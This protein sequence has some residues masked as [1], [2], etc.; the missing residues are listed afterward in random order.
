MITSFSHA[1]T[2]RFGSGSTILRARGN[3]PLSIEQLQTVAPSVFAAEAHASRSSRYTYIPTVD[4][5]RGLMAEGF[6]PY[7]VR[8]GGS[9]DEA[10]RGFTKH[11]L[12]LRHASQGAALVGGDSVR[13]LILL[14]AHDGT[15]SYQLMSGLFRM[16]CTNGL[17]TCEGGEML[18]IAHKGDIISNVIEG[19][20]QILADSAVIG[21]RVEALQ[22]LTLSTGE[23]EA[24]AAAAL[25]LRYTAK[26]DAGIVQAAP[27]EPRQVNMPHRT[28]DQGADM[29][30]TFN[31]V[32]E[33]LINGGS[34]YVHRAANGQRS[35]RHTRPVNSIDG[36]VNLNRALWT[37]ATKMQ[38][39][40]AA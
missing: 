13:E 33:N 27:I 22:G 2:A 28:A 31:R 20:Y 18:R 19:S 11:M 15:S 4:V 34:S 35:H 24:F 39:L 6:A 10:K 38:E 36:N 30:K 8:Q 14:N 9:R 25:E 17:I 5:L 12:R 29:W 23:Q 3:E 26:D 37:L 7:E 32:Q 16:V 40:K 1:H 21:E